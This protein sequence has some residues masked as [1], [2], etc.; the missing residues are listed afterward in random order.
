MLLVELCSKMKPLGHSVAFHV[1]RAVFQKF[2]WVGLC[3][4]MKPLGHSVVFHV[5]KAVFQNE[6]LGTQCGI[7]R[8]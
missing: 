6:A 2:T 7:S 1:G 8:G 5:G 3:S 4:K